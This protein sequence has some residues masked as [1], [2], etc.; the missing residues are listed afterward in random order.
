MS[1]KSY[2]P[3]SQGLLLMECIC[4]LLYWV[5]NIILS[6]NSSHVYDVETYSTIQIMFSDETDTN[7]LGMCVHLL[8]I[9]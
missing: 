9:V 6:C 3:F 2:Y 7:M 4:S 8:L 1:L 5:H